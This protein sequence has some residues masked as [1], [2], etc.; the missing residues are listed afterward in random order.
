MHLGNHFILCA[1]P[2][3][4]IYTLTLLCVI[5]HHVASTHSPQYMYWNLS[6]RVHVHLNI[7]TKASHFMYTITS[8]YVL[9]NHFITS[10]HSPQ[11]ILKPIS[12]HEHIHLN[13]SLK[14]HL[15]SCNRKFNKRS[16]PHHCRYTITSLCEYKQ[17]GVCI[18]PSH[19]TYT[20]NLVYACI[21]SPHFIY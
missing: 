6:Y 14:I 19:Y 3:H 4:C 13:I 21:Y 7:C 20:D 10:T 5:N 2:S 12:L 15:I 9:K 18:K 16:L 11:Y 8:I 1:K 17:V